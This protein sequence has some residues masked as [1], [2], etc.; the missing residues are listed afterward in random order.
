MLEG[1]FDQRQVTVKFELAADIGA[2]SFDRA[3]AD[4]Q[5][6]GDL[7]A[8]LVLG[9][10]LEDASF[11][12]RQVFESGFARVQ[13]GGALSAFEEICGEVWADVGLAGG[14]GFD[15]SYNVGDGAVFEHIAFR[16]DI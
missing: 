8:A 4:E 5:L 2:V 14:D 7:F 16:A 15:G 12:G 3:V 9:D 11:G 6:S 10:Q 13:V 1:E